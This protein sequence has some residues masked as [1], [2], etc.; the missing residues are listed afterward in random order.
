MGV[1]RRCPD[2]GGIPT[3]RVVGRY[4]YYHKAIQIRECPWCDLMWSDTHIDP[5]IIARHFEKSY[6]DDTYFRVSRNRVFAHLATIIDQL[7]P[8][9]GSVLD[10]GGARGDLMSHVAGRRP[11]LTLVVNDISES[12][13]QWASDYYGFA[14]ITGSAETLVQH[15]RQYDVVVLSDVLYYEPKL[16]TLWLALAHLVKEG[17]SVVFRIPNKYHLISAAQWW[18]RLTHTSEEQLSQQRIKYF[19]PEHI[20][21]IRPQYLWRRLKFLG[22]SEFKWLPSPLSRDSVAGAAL[23]R[24]SDWINRVSLNSVV[25]TP[26]MVVVARKGVVDG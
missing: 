18:Y 15:Q 9:N 24:F 4:T 2:C 8:P 25:T 12:A 11:F 5:T 3:P 16:S 26:S 6:K 7:A 22:F 14:T 23:F 13:T 20:F 19:N 10:I 1:I 21:I 17:G